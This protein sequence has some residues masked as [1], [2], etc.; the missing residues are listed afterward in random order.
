MKSALFDGGE[1]RRMLKA[2]EQALVWG[3]CGGNYRFED[4][5][6]KNLTALVG[7]AEPQHTAGVAWLRQEQ[8][9]TCILTE[10]SVSGR[11]LADM[12]ISDFGF[13]IFF[14]IGF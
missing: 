1:R 9:R 6:L 3:G 10:Y 7:D 14:F 12:Q 4:E 8:L 5:I 2:C 13:L 11:N